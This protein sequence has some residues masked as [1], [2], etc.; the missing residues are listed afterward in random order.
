AAED[1]EDEEAPLSAAQAAWEKA[2][3]ANPKSQLPPPVRAALKADSAKRSD[4]QKQAL[5]E[6]FVRHAYPM[7]R[8]GF[9]PL[10]KEA[11]RLKKAEADLQAAIPE[12]MVMQE[13]PRPRDTFVLLRGDFRVKGAKV[14]PGVPAS[15]PPLPKDLP[16]NRLALAKWLTDPQHPLTARATV[17]RLWALSFGAGLGKTS[18]GFGPQGELPSHPELLDWL[19][20][21]FV[22]SGWDVKALQRLIVTSAAYRQESKADR[23]LLERDPHNRLLARGPRF[24]L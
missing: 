24:R 13:M 12:T 22:A 7:A 2:E 16:A 6:H 9:A 18:T 11:E 10:N 14:S 4:A 15:L 21:E 5:R 3:R 8:A 17:N 23:A 20:T 1:A 19:A